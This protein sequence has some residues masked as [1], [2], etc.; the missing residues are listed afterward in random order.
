MRSL[1]KA[2]KGLWSLAVG[3]RI[4]AVELVKP[5]ITV[6][7]P[8]QEVKNLAYLPRPHRARA[9]GCGPPDAALHHV[10]ALC[11]QLPLALHHPAHARQGRGGRPGRG[12]GPAACAGRPGALFPAP[13]PPPD[14]IERVLDVYR[15]NYSLC[16]L[17]GLCVQNCPV[18]AIRFTGNAYLVG[19]TRQTF[20]IDLLARLRQRAAARPQPAARPAPRKAQGGK[21]LMEQ[22]AA[23][24]AYGLYLALIV[25]GG[26]AAV[27]CRNLVRALIGL[28]MTLFGVA[29]M[30]FL[31]A[32]PF[33]ALMQILIYV[34]AVSVL[35][36]FAIMLTRA[37]G[38]EAGNES[39][40]R[41]TGLRELLAVASG[42]L[43]AV[44]LAGIVA[45]QR[46]AGPAPE[47]RGP[48]GAAGAVPDRALRAGLRA[49]FGGAGGG[50]GRGGAARLREEEGTMNP[51]VL[52][53][54]AALL[55]L[56]LGLY[57]IT[58]RRSLVGM[59]IAVELML[60]G[61]GLALVASARL[62]PAADELGQLGALLVMGLAAAEATLVLAIILVVAKRW[63]TSDSAT[64]S[65]LR[66]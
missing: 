34:G 56:G 3:L 12:P 15:L 17:C 2:L 66:G 61:A 64:I 62:T 43:P 40:R 48:A 55:L 52:F 41:R 4:T 47:G 46:P 60:N 26:L 8:R 7:Y 13:A 28:I 63:G 14:Q 27:R 51:L 16:S 59:L 18:D 9:A 6:H 45:G 1:I 42:L 49:D 39:S 31:M 29:G 53:H 58:S 33:L 44:I 24:V 21:R 57:G 23:H 50:H 36:F 30:Y 35:I 19:T 25:A 38:G 20:D 10:L 65:S 54:L 37:P 22:L 32:A 11:R 5:Q